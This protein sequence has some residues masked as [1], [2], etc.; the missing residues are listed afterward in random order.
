MLKNWLYHQFDQN[1]WNSKG[2]SLLN[3]LSI[4]FIL[5]AVILQILETEQTI[6]EPNKHLFY[7][8]DWV[9]A[10]IFTLEFSLRLWSY[11]LNP[12]YKGIR[13]RLRYLKKPRNIID[14]IT[15]IP[16]YA[17]LGS[18][19]WLWL[20]SLRALRVFSLIRHRVLMSAFR[21]L[22]KAVSS[23]KTELL[24]TLI[25][26]LTMLFTSATFLYLIERNVQP[27]TFGSI[28]RA[29]WWSIATLTTVGYGDVTPITALGKFVAGITALIGLAL[30]AMPTGILAAAFS[31][32]FQKR[33]EEK[34]RV[35]ENCLT[36]V[37]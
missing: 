24:V 18:S 17:T 23:R 33:R 29:L 26:A 2:I 37:Y 27:E 12:Q 9:L 25:L 5:A 3:M 20:R 8:A 30:V 31:N 19:S 15:L 1:H 13:G 4:F 28:P 11:G 35:K 7:W 6:Y 16:F 34:E 21:L 14:I 36:D 22:Y 10:I 32:E